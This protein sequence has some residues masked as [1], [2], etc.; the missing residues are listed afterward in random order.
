MGKLPRFK[1]RVFGHC[2]SMSASELEEC[3]RSNE[4][5]NAIKRGLNKIL[6]KIDPPSK[7][8]EDLEK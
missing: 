3:Q 7:D 5:K 8:E 2:P 4:R 1:E 6:D